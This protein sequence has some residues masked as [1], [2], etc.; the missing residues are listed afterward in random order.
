M[1][2]LAHTCFIGTTGY[3]N[4]ARSFFVALNK[5]HNVKVRNDTVGVTWQ[6]YS[7][8]PH[9]D[10]FYM[11][12]EMKSMLYQQSLIV[13][14]NGFNDFPIYSYN[15]DFKPDVHIILSEMNNHYFYDDYEGY[16]IA[17]NVWESTEYPKD[18]FE[19][20]FYFDEVWVPSSWQKENLIN[21]G[22]PEN[23][24]YIV[25]EGVDTKVFKPAEEIISKSKFTFLLFGRWEYRKSTTEIIRT[26]G[27]TF[28]DLTD[29][30]ELICSVENNFSFDGLN[31]TEE[32][33][34]HH[35]LFYDNI[36]F[37]D[38]PSREEYVKYL[39][40]G[41]VFLSCS[42]SE[43]WFLPLI[44]SMSCGTPSIYSDWGAQLEYAKDK[45]IPVKIKGLSPANY[46]HNWPGFYCE[47]DL[48]NLSQKMLDVYNNY[49]SFKQK[50]LKDGEFIRE[51]FTWEKAAEKADKILNRKDDF[52]FITT[53]DIGY[54][55]VI[56]QLASSLL[57]FSKHKLIVYGVNCDVPINMPNVINRRMDIPFKSKH[58]KWYWKQHSCIEVLKEDYKF[59]VWID[60]DVVVNHNIDTISQYF[61]MIKDYPISDIHHQED[62]FGTYT[63]KN[64]NLT[65][66][67]N[68]NLLK[69]N[70]IEKK[71]PIAHVCLFIFNKDCKWWFEEILKMYAEV[72]LEK[73]QHLYFWNDESMD[74]FLRCKYNKNDHLPLSNFDTSGYDGYGSQN[75]TMN[76]FLTFWNKPGPY[77][78]DKIYGYQ[79]I[80]ENKNQILYFH[81][82]KDKKTSREMIKFIKEV[83]DK[84]FHKTM[85]FYTKLYHIEDFSDVLEVR[86]STLYVAEKYGWDRA[87]FHEIF[88]L[89][90]YYH[91]N[92]NHIKEGDVVVDLGGN[93]GIFNRWAYF[94]GASK[95]ISFEPDKRYFKLLSLN[96]DSRSL[97]FNAAVS[98]KMGEIDIYESDH[99]GG[100]TTFKSY[101]YKNKYKVRTYTLDY[102]FE[103]KL[104]DKIDFLKIDIE[105]SEIAAL[106]GI[107]DENLMKVK[108]I[109]MEYHHKHL[110]F[111]EKLREE[112]ILRLNK[113]GFNSYLLFLGTDNSLQMI[114]FWR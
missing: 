71:Y 13:E 109:S 102:L 7:K 20:L 59:F 74:N 96:S 70:K 25:P 5:L 81:G 55:P 73:Y 31:N 3:A 64:H 29:D 87:I 108:N 112:L 93:I 36:K 49:S 40:Q 46:E 33:V 65:Q 91:E 11:T 37:I 79:H 77:N 48:E 56:E 52:V 22:Y 30:V 44:E 66:R 94:E 57:E 2:I 84:S 24:I 53:G 32:R 85:R 27:E 4:H 60:G 113:L 47:P 58:D 23:K 99:L 18:F 41:D 38:Y 78:F 61:N 110:N 12:D 54:M 1:N 45:G 105:G 10:E 75:D 63:Y 39:Q 86:G 51:E 97:L 76:H 95:V 82:N 69:E 107:S 34:K 90:D 43:G 80:P 103:T 98:N 68:E 92:F 101:S 28:K 89:K 6:E 17:Y 42:R 9:N 16:K 114:Y 19:R 21:Q 72:D 83:R 35:K 88:N 8:E 15:K 50:A 104:I 67:F 111:D 106:N 100:T 14:G 62:F 26:F